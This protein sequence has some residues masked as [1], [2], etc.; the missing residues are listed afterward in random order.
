MGINRHSVPEFS[1]VDIRQPV[2]TGSF[3]LYQTM[4]NNDDECHEDVGRH[5]HFDMNDGLF[6]AHTEGVYLFLFNGLAHPA[7]QTCVQLRVNFTDLRASAWAVSHDYTDKYS[8]VTLYAT[9]SLRRGDR[10]GVL[11]A[12]GGMLSA[13][14]CGFLLE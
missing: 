1:V 10:I 11:L 9:V 14:F 4:E 6:T 7:G 13:S 12:S 3:L 8:T 2:P 5:G